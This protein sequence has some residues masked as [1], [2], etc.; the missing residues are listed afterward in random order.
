[1][2]SSMPKVRVL[3]ADDHA[4]VAEGLKSLLKDHFE[5]VGVVHDGRALL[6][7][8]EK[9]RP[10]VIVTDISMPL[11]NGLD[12]VRQ[13][14]AQRPETRIIIL[15]MHRDTHLAASAFRAGVS[16]Y[17]LKISPG[18]ELVNAIREVAQGHS[19]V[20]TLLAKDLINLLMD[21][22]PER[23]NESPLT[24]RQREVLQLIAEGRTMKEV[25]AV[26][27]ISPRTAESHKYDIMQ[28][29]GVATT[30]E[31]VQCAVRMKLVDE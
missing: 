18:E 7:A 24:P 25:A 21:S 22:G 12:A 11:L 16:G 14:H 15:T 19:F 20:T 6:D 13:I 27:N 31:L 17:L 10:D 8:A 23:E 5:L 28:A 1:V 2:A 4:L 3:L 9:L 29:L 30:A 26:L